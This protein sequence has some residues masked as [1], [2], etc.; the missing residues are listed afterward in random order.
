MPLRGVQLARDRTSDSTS[1]VLEYRVT[2]TRCHPTKYERV[3]A[4]GNASGALRFSRL[5]IGCQRG[6]V[7][8][9]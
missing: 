7:M 2:V 6:D 4:L 3:F 1:N 9:H 8:F 5:L